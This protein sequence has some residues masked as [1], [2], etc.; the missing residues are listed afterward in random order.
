MWRAGAPRT[1]IGR[2]EISSTHSRRFPQQRHCVPPRRHHHQHDDR[3]RIGST[4][5]NFDDA[6]LHEGMSFTSRTLLPDVE[7]NDP[8]ATEE[9]DANSPGGTDMCIR[10]RRTSG[11]SEGET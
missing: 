8:G 7:L 1:L 6:A 2:A 5:M 9:C 3:H 11:A 10:V 4:E